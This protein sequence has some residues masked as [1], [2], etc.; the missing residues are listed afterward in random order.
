V[1]VVSVAIVPAVLFT[2]DCG[3]SG[4]T[5]TATTG[6]TGTTVTQTTGTTESTTEPSTATSQFTVD[7][8]VAVDGSVVLSV[9]PVV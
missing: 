9:A 2:V 3:T 4:T 1:P 8:D 6:T 7:W 5:A